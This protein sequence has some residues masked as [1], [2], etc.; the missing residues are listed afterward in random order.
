[1]GMVRHLAWVF[2]VLLPV[3]GCAARVRYCAPS[4]INP[5]FLTDLDSAPG[6]YM[7]IDPGAIPKLVPNTPTESG[8]GLPPLNVLAISGGGM[9]GAF[10][11]GVLHGW[12]ESRTR[13]QFDVV[14]GVSTG[15]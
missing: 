11:V 7:P 10:D 12:T 3:T 9:Y 6:E 13:P 2:V 14:T 1:M 4:N 5:A 15:A 8:K